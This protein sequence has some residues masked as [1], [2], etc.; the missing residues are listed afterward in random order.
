MHNLCGT[1]K[2]GYFSGTSVYR[3]WVEAPSQ[4]LENWVW[5]PQVLPTLS[6]NVK[7][8][9]KKLPPELLE[10]MIQAKNLNNG[11]KY[12]RQTFFAM[13]DMR[14]HTQPTVNTTD[15]WHEGMR[16][17]FGVPASPGTSE[18]GSFGHLFGYEAGYYSYLWS[19]VFAADMFSRFSRDGV[20]NEKTGRAYR[21][22]I[23]A[24]GGSAEPMDL[25]KAFLGRE[26]NQEAFL[27][28]IGVR[29]PTGAKPA[30]RPVGTN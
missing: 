25:L 11:L 16:D 20:M 8:R 7:D 22:Q 18:E 17:I 27:E 14:Y 15:V 9:S 13:T 4:M 12:S 1:A 24:P 10:R 26:P 6:G 3:D 5:D 30:E 21:D 23:L 19:E 29:P 28:H 2:L